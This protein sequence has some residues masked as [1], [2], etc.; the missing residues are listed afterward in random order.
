MKRKTMKTATK[1]AWLGADIYRRVV[2]LAAFWGTFDLLG[3]VNYPLHDMIVD[4]ENL[5][6]VALFSDDENVDWD[7]LEKRRARKIREETD[8][9]GT[10]KNHIKGL[11]VALRR[12]EKVAKGEALVETETERESL[13]NTIAEIKSHC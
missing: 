9:Y 7:A 4:A 6:S 5:K 1:T 2:A 10:I 12:Y 11:V 13:W 3:A 8:E